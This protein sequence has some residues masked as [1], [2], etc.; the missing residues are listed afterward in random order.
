MADVKFRV[1]LAACAVYNLQFDVGEHHCL[2]PA[3]GKDRRTERHLR[4]RS[5]WLTVPGT[6][7]G[8]GLLAQALSHYVATLQGG[9]RVLGTELRPSHMLGTSIAKFY[10][11]TY[12]DLFP[13][14]FE[15]GSWV[16]SPG[17]LCRPGWTGTCSDP[18]ASRVLGKLAVT[19]AACSVVLF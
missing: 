14:L 10:S 13:F 6:E 12:F 3:T 7:A 5:S 8:L 4:A 18:S 15:T 16:C 11:Q 9:R 19:I 1:G 17:K 2:L